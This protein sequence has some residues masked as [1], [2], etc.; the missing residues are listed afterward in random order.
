MADTRV[1]HSDGLWEETVLVSGLD[2]QK[3][4]NM[5][6]EFLITYCIWTSLF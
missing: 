6:F 5:S 2:Q 3:N 1:H 4:Q